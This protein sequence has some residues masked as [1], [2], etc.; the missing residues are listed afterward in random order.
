MLQSEFLTLIKKDSID[1]TDY[2][3][4]EKVYTYHPAIMDKK[5]IADLY[6]NFGMTVIYDMYPRTEK[7]MDIETRLQF[8]KQK[9][10][11]FEDELRQAKSVK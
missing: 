7:I 1:S 5:H 4:I 2:E 6:L 11:Q 9:V 3:L 10:T 8:A